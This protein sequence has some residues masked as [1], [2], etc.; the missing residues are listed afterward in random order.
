MIEIIAFGDNANKNTFDMVAPGST[1]STSTSQILSRDHSRS[2]RPA[3][4]V[5]REMAM[6]SGVGDN[7]AGTAVRSI[8]G[9]A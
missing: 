5:D 9:A 2:E 6:R 8:P 4:A 7:P 3:I 1:R